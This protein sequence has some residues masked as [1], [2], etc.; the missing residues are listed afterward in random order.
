MT[1]ARI[2]M[3]VGVALSLVSML[4][5]APAL[6]QEKRGKNSQSEAGAKWLADAGDRFFFVFNGSGEYLRFTTDKAPRPP[7]LQ[8]KV[9]LITKE[10]AA[11]V[12]Q[13]LVDC[14]M[15]GRSDTLPE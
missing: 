13:T 8:G 6:G 7:G 10:E 3:S 5:T 11:A 14:G 4:G 15:W 2:L 9:F 1:M 12:V